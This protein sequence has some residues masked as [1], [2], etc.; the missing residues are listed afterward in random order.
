M[1]PR[2]HTRSNREA[3]KGKQTRRT[4]EFRRLIGRSLHR[5]VR[6]VAAGRRTLQIDCDV[7]RP[8][9]APAAAITGAWP[10][11]AVSLL[12]ETKLTRNPIV[13]P[14]AAISVGLVQGQPLLDWNTWKA[15]TA[16]PI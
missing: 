11:D 15:W 9:A 16:V 1:L 4:Q 13:Q 7:L 2:A 14:V 12:A 5:S 10:H 3:A 6:F 8:T